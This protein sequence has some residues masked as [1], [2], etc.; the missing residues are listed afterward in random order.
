MKFGSQSIDILNL[1]L[2][3]IALILA[4]AIPFK[5]F[6]FAYAFI[7]P[8]HYLT[9]INWLHGKSYFIKRRKWIIWPILL[10]IIFVFP[11]LFSLPE[12]SNQ[13]VFTETTLTKSFSW[14]S[15]CIWL[16]LFMAL[17]LVISQSSKG[18]II[19]VGAGVLSMFLLRSIPVYNIWIGLLLPTLIHVFLFTLFFML[20]GS[21]RTNSYVGYLNCIVMVIIPILIWRAPITGQN[22]WLTE[23]MKFNFTQNNFHVLNATVS[24]ILGLSEGREFYFLGG[25]SY[26][27]QVFISFAYFYHYLN[28]FSK[29]TVIGWHK[30]LTQQ[31]SIYLFSAWLLFA[32]LVIL[33]YQMGI[34]VL[35]LLSILHVFLEFPLNLISVKSI[36]SEFQMRLLKFRQ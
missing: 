1:V 33:N 31:K 20:L 6:L 21:L 32:S 22:I 30:M 28:W 7:G 36:I 9:E 13:K 25:K 2:I 17:G 23:G 18:R 24:K 34:T 5:L 19:L 11:Y 16:A 14:I 26:K 8:L 35:M 27:I 15:G 3:I 12:L 29:T 10:S 4:I